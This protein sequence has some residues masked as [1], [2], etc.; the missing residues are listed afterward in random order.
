MGDLS[1]TIPALFVFAALLLKLPALRRNPQDVLL[2]AV[3]A[4]LLVAALVFLLGAVP[5]IAAVNRVTGVPN[6]AAPLVY[7]VLSAFSGACVVLVLIWRTGPTPRTM[8]ACRL[9]VI[10]YGVVILSLNAL[11]ALGDAPV[12]RLRDLD[13]YYANT[14]FI[15]EM[16]VLYLLAHTVAAVVVTVLC[17]R[18]S[19]RVGGVLRAGLVLIVVGYLLNLGYDAAKFSAIGARWG[20]HDWDSLSTHVARPIA[21]VS[22]VLIGI[23]FVLP[24]LGQR[25]GISWR[26][27]VR[28]R[29]LGPLAHELSGT[30]GYGSPGVA[31]GRW[32]SLELRLTQREA[33]IHDAIIHLRP[34]FDHALHRD[35]NDSALAQ[36]DSPTQARIVADAAMIAAA[37]KAQTADPGRTTLAE[38]AESVQPSTR[39]DDLVQMSRALRRSPLV[40]E[41]CR[42]TA[43]SGSSSP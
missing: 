43:L 30:T 7:S 27:A 31:I 29:Q 15:R 1:M 34:Y 17:W 20:G 38:G 41:A 39:A 10:G 24:H 13:T 32:A 23:G 14:P 25:L 40:H 28:F 16:I 11:F 22:A 33:A 37:G 8:R 18:W 42:R 2:R 21:S 19:L 3:C 26:T 35:T 12:E 6:L 9:C 5:V 4:L 36:G